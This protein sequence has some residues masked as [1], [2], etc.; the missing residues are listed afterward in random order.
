[1]FRSLP[2]I[3][4]LLTG[5]CAGVGAYTFHFAQ[6]LSYFSNNPDSCANCHIMRDYLDSWQKSSHHTRAVCNDCHSPHSLVPKLLTKADNGWN[7]SVK[8]TLQTFNDP[9][10]I[11]AV[12][13]G[14]VH[15]N[16][17][18][19]H[20][21]LVEDIQSAPAHGGAQD[22]DCVHCHAGVGHGPRR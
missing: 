18:R 1:M 15:E 19:C 4:S 5:L 21:D 11:R 13:A 12:N 8:F 16:C 9:I 20:Q 6:G 2:A 14:R 10:R 22:A 7:H 3:L 17:V